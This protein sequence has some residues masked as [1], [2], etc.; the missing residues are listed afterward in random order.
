MLESA[1]PRMAQHSI[2][3]ST[4]AAHLVVCPVVC[5]GGIKPTSKFM[6]TR[7]LTIFD[8]LSKVSGNYFLFMFKIPNQ[9]F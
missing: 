1:P 3:R 9:L 8:K 2:P 7:S 4:L 6:E 5:R